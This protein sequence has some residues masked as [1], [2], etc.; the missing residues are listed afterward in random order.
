MHTSIG[1]IMSR[2]IV[3]VKPEESAGSAARL[4]EQ[5]G[6]GALPIVDGEKNLKGILTDRD[7][8]VR[9]VAKDRDPKE[10][11]A[12][13][14]MTDRIVYVSAEQPVSEAVAMMASEQ[15]RRLP[16]VEDGKI[17]GMISFADIARRDTSP[18]VAEAIAE[19][20][21]PGSSENEVVRR[22]EPRV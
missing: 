15:I 12:G 7:I 11:S 3:S 9:C 18:E 21:S 17:V 22:Y 4:M 2:E 19:I 6:V 5:H 8:V 20:S 10:V 13:E 1:Q 16:V 14:I